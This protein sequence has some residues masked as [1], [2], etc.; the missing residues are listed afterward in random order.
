[1]PHRRRRRIVEPVTEF[2]TETTESDLPSVTRMLLRADGSMTRLLEALIDRP[3]ALDLTDQHTTTGHDLDPAVRAALGCAD[4][5]AVVVRR[6]TLVTTGGAA[7]SWNCVAVV[8]ADDELTAL[9]TDERLPIGHSLAGARR[10]LARTVLG[11]GVTRWP[12]AGEGEGLPCAYKESVL[13]DHRSAVVAHL[14]ERFNPT[15]VPLAAAR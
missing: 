6:S 11:A 8:A 14:H 1:M 7:V 3:L 4:A 5:D 10:H 9:L 2:L 13:S 15:Y 12:V